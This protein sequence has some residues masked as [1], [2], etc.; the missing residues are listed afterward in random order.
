MKCFLSQRKSRY[1]AY[2]IADKVVGR[3]IVIAGRADLVN[4]PRYSSVNDRHTHMGELLSAI[5]EAVPSRT[6]RE[7]LD[8]CQTQGI[9]ATDLLDLAHAHENAYVLDQGLI[10][11]R[12]HPTEGEYYATPHSVRDVAHTDF[13][14]PTRSLAR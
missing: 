13:V 14:Q 4:N 7:W 3:Y 5:R 11:K 10:T 12:E 6:T 9:P 2:V 8:L 1:A